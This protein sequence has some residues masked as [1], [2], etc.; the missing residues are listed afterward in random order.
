MKSMRPVIT[1][2]SMGMWL[3][4]VGACTSVLLNTPVSKNAEGWVVTLSQVKDG[5]NEYVGEVSTVIPGPREQLIWTMLTVKNESGQEQSFSYE[6]C[7]L[8]GK[9]VA[10]RPAI[11]DRNAAELRSPADGNESFDNGVERTR[12]LVFEF[13]K[14]V[15]PTRLK[16]G[17][18]VLPIPAPR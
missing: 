5:P 9:G 11:V 10:Q 12:Q 18:I 2:L 6:T 16:C 14:D 13:P 1:I 17:A 7:T 4:G 3:G 8:E 15:R